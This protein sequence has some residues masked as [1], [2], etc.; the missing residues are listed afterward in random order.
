[1]ARNYYASQVN[2]EK[3]MH[4]NYYYVRH[5]YQNEEC[6]IRLFGNRKTDELAIVKTWKVARVKYNALVMTFNDRK[7]AEQEFRSLVHYEMSGLY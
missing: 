3:T 7:E 6:V 2:A 5:E 1:M 4:A